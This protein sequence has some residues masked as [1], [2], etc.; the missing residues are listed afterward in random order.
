MYTELLNDMREC[1]AITELENGKITIP[2]F[3]NRLDRINKDRKEYEQRGI[4]DNE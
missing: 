2:Q 4:K 1:D 3:E